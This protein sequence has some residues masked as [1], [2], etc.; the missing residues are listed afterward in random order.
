MPM[1]F[2]GCDQRFLSSTSAF[3]CLTSYEVSDTSSKLANSASV[4]VAEAA[5]SAISAEIRLD[6]TFLWFDDDLDFLL[7]V[8]VGGGV[9]ATG[10]GG[11]VAASLIASS[12]TVLHVGVKISLYLSFSTLVEAA[13]LKKNKKF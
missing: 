7:E 8:V 3:V 10:A 2:K 13:I 5:T 9:G 4:M 12:L 11:G 1:T 6:S